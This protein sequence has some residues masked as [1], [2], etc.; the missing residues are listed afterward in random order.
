MYAMDITGVT[1]FS[2]AFIYLLFN[3]L[4]LP[5]VIPIHFGLNGVADRYASKWQLLLFP[6]LTFLMGLALQFLEKHPEWHNYPTHRNDKNIEI[7]YRQSVFMLSFIKNMIFILLAFL[8]WEAIHL[9]EGYKETLQFIIW[10]LLAT[11]I[12]VPTI[13]TIYS[14]IKYL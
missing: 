1:V 2:I 12:L 10:I 3:L 13:V 11:I 8:S 9:A 5:D 7:Q 14:S 6:G 4:Q